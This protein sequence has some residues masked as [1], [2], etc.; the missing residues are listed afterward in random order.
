MALLE[1]V[2]QETDEESLRT[3]ASEI[4]NVKDAELQTLINDM[5]D[6]LHEA[7]GVGLAA[8]QVGRKIKLAII[9]T[10]PDYDED[11]EPIEGTRDLYVIIN[12][13]I[14]WSSRKTMD[15]I[16][17]CLSIPGYLG[18]VERPFA[19]RVQA[20]DRHGRKKRYRLKGWDARI[21]QH[22]IDHLNGIL[23]TD[24]LTSADRYWTEEEYEAY[25]KEQEEADKEPV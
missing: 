18:E 19:I 4:K 24:I 20:L 13:K 25:R 14:V 12:P 10:L 11:D 1:I 8:P 3:V 9:E 23:Y 15:G 5:I 2:T 17:G 16:E 21:F 22:E 7:E 6:T